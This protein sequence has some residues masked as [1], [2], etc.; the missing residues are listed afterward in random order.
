VLIILALCLP[1][2]YFNTMTNQ[3]LIARKRQM[4]WTKVMILA[5]IVNPLC[6]LL[7]IP[8]FQRTHGNG[9]IGAAISLLITELVITAIG[10]VLIRRALGAGT[11]VRLAKALVA[12]AAM[13]IIVQLTLH[14][15]GL[16]AAILAGVVLFPVFVLLLR[17]LTEDERAQAM[18][19]V[20]RLRRR[21]TQPAP[22]A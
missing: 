15:G 5:T 9:A 12:T 17:V 10:I 18:Q 11:L 13:G 14:H 1:P 4:D 7:L 6:N 20:A 2:M 21:G 8:Y 3:V 22:S 16:A 19:V